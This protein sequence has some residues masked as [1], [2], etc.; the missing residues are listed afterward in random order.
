VTSRL[1][2]TA[3]ED[4]D[5]E[6]PQL[7]AVQRL[8][9]R[10]AA[11]LDG[12]DPLAGSVRSVVLSIEG[13]LDT[14]ALHGA[15][16]H[17]LA[18]HEG[19]SVQRTE[20]APSL[21]TL[22]LPSTPPPT[23]DVIHIL[24]AD[25]GRLAAAADEARR[26]LDP[27]RGLLVRFVAQPRPHGADVLVV[28]H[29]LACDEA[30]LLVLAED[31]AAA[32]GAIS[33]GGKPATEPAVGA[34]ECVDLQRELV[35]TPP[36]AEE[37]AA[38]RQVL[39]IEADPM[40]TADPI[41]AE[42]TLRVDG[43]TG[44]PEETA[45]AVLTALASLPEQ[46]IGTLVELDLGLR[47]RY[48]GPGAGRAVLPL[49]EPVMLRR[50]TEIDRDRA[51]AAVSGA[52]AT[53][54]RLE[55]YRHF[56][57]RTAREFGGGV[58]PRV[59]IELH[60]APA[61]ALP[62][63]WAVTAHRGRDLGRRPAGFDLVVAV[64]DAAPGTA[65]AEVRLLGDEALLDALAV[66]LREQLT[67]R[68]VD[69]ELVEVTDAE[70]A[71]IEAGSRYPVAAVLPTSPLQAGMYL[72][73]VMDEDRDVY[74]CQVTLHVG[75][76]LDAAR[77]GRAYDEV[78]ARHP[79]TRMGFTGEPAAGLVEFVVDDVRTEVAELDLRAEPDPDAALRAFR[80]RDRETR[81]VL[82]DPPLSRLTVV[83][84]PDGDVLV[85]TFHLLLWDGWSSGIVLYELFDRYRGE[86]PA[87]KEI[88]EWREFLRWVD[89]RDRT[90]GLARWGEYLAG[91]EP[92]L[93]APSARG[94]ELVVAETIN[95]PLPEALT[96][97]LSACARHLGVTLNALLTAALGITL[98]H[99]AG[100]P[101][102][103]FGSTV[104]GRPTELDGVAGTVGVFMNTVPVR[105]ELDPAETVAELVGRL[106]GDRADL[107]EFD[108]LG[109]GDIQQ[110]HGGREL[111]DSLYTLQ[112]FL[113]DGFEKFS[114]ANGIGDVQMVD[115]THFPL[116]WVVTPGRRMNVK[117]EFRPDLVERPAA[118]T[119]LARYV[120]VL[121]RL[122]ADPTARVGGLDVRTAAE[123]SA[124]T[125]SRSTAVDDVT[126]AELLGQQARTTPDRV[127][128]VFG[129]ERLTFAELDARVSRMARLLRSRGAGPEQ[130]VAL[131]LPRSVD[132]VVALFA[133]LRA[134]AA[135]LPLELE[136]PTERLTAL[137]ADAHAHLLVCADDRLVGAGVTALRLDDPAVRS[138]LDE[139]PGTDLTDE[140][141]GPFAPG[142]R[143]RGEFPAY[144]IYTSG[145]TGRPKGV[146]TPYRGL[147]NMLVNHRTEIFGPTVARAGG[148]VL[149]IA[150][151]VSFAFD[152][153]WEELL[154]L[155]DGHEV[156]VCDEQ[157][158][159]DAEA[160]VAYCDI[161]E[162]DSVNVTPT[163]AH[164]LFNAGL[165]DD[166]PGRHRPVL[167]LLGGEAV[168]ESVWSR[169][170]DTEGTWGYNLY[171]PTEY[172]I[173]TLGGGTDDSSTSTV[174]RP[175]TNTR[176]HILDTWL[177]PVPDGVAGELYIS[178]IGLARGYLDQ[179]GLTAGTFVADPATPGQRMYR[180]GDV[181]RR[182][183]DGNLD[184]L[185]RGDDQ[186]KI[187]GYRVELGEVENTLA[188]VDGVEQVAVITREHPVVPG[189]RQLA[190]FLVGAADPA[191]VRDAAARTLPE[192]MVP[193][194]W[195]TVAA[196]PLTVNG[197]LD[198]ESLP[199]PA[200]LPS[201]SSRAPRTPTEEILCGIVAEVL[202]VDGI[203]I[204]DDFF[205]LGG[206][207]ISVLT[208]ANRARKA[209][210]RIRPRNV[211]E[212]RTVAR[213]AELLD[214]PM[215]DSAPAPAAEKAALPSAGR[216]LAEVAAT[217]RTG[218]APA[219][220]G[221]VRM[222]AHEQ[223][224]GPSAT[225]L[226]P[227]VHRVTGPLHTV[228]LAAAVA[229][230]ADR[231]PVLRTTYH[232]R[233][234]AV[235]QRVDPALRPAFDLRDVSA[236][237]MDGEVAAVVR[238]PFALDSECPLRLSV[239]RVA[240]EDHVVALVI[241]HIAVDEW[242]VRALLADLSTAYAAR[243]KGRAPE[244][245]TLAVS[246]ADFAT[247]QH[248]HL[249]DRADDDS[250]AA[251]QL[252]HWE[253]A[254]AGIPEETTLPSRSGRP[255]QRTGA[256]AEVYTLLDAELTQRLKATADR[257]QVS[258]FMLAHSA[259]AVLLDAHGCGPDVVIGSPISERGDDALTDVL[260]FFL[261]T[262]ALRLDL[263]GNPT[264]AEVLERA[265]DT[266]LDAMAH[267]D[268]PFDWVV[269]RV[270][271]ERSASRH[272]LFQVELV[273]LRSDM[274]EGGLSLSGAVAERV[275][276]ATGTAKFDATFQFYERSG[277]DP[278]IRLAVEYATDLFSEAEMTDIVD[279]LHRLLE[280]VAD[281]PER[282]LADLRWP[283]GDVPHSEPPRTDPT[284]TLATL[285]AEVAGRTPE[286]TAL[287]DGSDRLSYAELQDRAARLAGALVERGVVPG[288]RVAIA[289]PRSA[290]MLVAVLGVLRA[291]ATYVPLDV[292]A[293]AE[294]LAMI[295]D[296]SGARC[297][298]TTSAARGLVAGAETIVLDDCDSAAAIPPVPVPAAQPAY[299]IYTSGST[300]RPKGVEVPHSAVLDLLAAADRHYDFNGADAWSLFHSVAFDVSVF[301]M[302][303]AFAHGARLVVAD[304]DTVR[305][306]E[307]F[308]A[309]LERERV[310]VLSQTPSAFDQL[311]E[312]EPAGAGTALRY[313][314]FAGEALETRRLRPWYARHPEDAPRLVNMYGITETCVHTTF[315]E[316][317]AVDAE[318][319][320]SPVGGPLPGLEVLLFDR[321]L[322][323]VLPGVVGE[324]YVRGGQLAQGY[325][326]RPGL[327]A[328]RFVADPA[329]T[330][331]RLYRSGDLAR[332]SPDGELE[333]TGRADD[334]VK[335]RGF[336]VEPGEVE[337][338]LLA[339]PGVTRAVVVARP[340]RAGTELVAYVV[341]RA[342]GAT[343]RAE[344]GSALPGY[345][346]PAAVVVLDAIPLTLNGKLD[347]R[348]LPEPDLGGAGRE[349][350][351]PAEQAVATAFRRVLGLERVGVDDSFFALG[352]HSL[353][354]L[355]LAHGIA[356]ELGT[357]VS[358]RD[359]FEH[360]TVAGLA[361]LAGAAVAA[362]PPLR[363]LPRTGAAR[364]LSAGQRQM[365]AL[366]RMAGP[367][368]VY[369]VP[370]VLRLTGPLDAAALAAAWG[371]LVTRHEVLRT[372]HR[373]T[374]AIVLDPDAAPAWFTSV[375]VPAGAIDDRIREAV[376][377][378]F[379][380]AAEPPIRV[381]LMRV[382]AETHVL[383]A[384][385]HH[386]AVDEWS[387][388][389]LLLDL[390]RAY[391]A[392]RAGEEG[393]P[394]PR[395]QYADFAAWQAECLADG[396]AT[397]ATRQLEYWRD[398][399]AGAP[400]ECTLP[401]DRA[402]PTSPT[403]AGGV[404]RVEVGPELTAALH[405]VAREHD[406]T[407]FMLLHAAL[408]LLLSRH[409][410]SADVVIGTPISTRLDPALD[411][412]VGY[413][414]NTLA[415]RVDVAP[416]QTLAEL[417]AAVRAADLD[418]YDR[419]DVPFADVVT[420]VGPERRAG[421][422]PLFQV[423]LVCLSGDANYA[424]PVLDGLEV[425]A[426]YVGTRTAKFDA[427]LNFH[428]SP[429]LLT[430]FIEYSA[431]L[432]DQETA[433]RFA[434]RFV[435]VLGAFA[436]T[437]VAPIGAIDVLAP[438]DR[439][440]ELDRVVEGTVAVP[441][442]TV[443][444]LLSEQAARTP[445]RV[446]LVFG[447]ER[448]TFAELD[449]RVS[450]MA[451]LLRSRGAGPEQVVAL[452]LPRSVDMV[453]ALFAVLR[454]GAAYLPLELEHPTERLTALIA[455]AHAHLLVCADDRLVGAGATA[456]RLADPAV[457][458]ELD[459]LPGTDLTDEELGPF[460][461]SNT[462]RSEYPA[463]VIY[464][465]GS[466]GRPKGVVTP[467]RG[468]T[469]MLVN[470]RTEIFGPTVAR[471]GGR[472]LRIAHTVSFAFDMSWEELL[473]LVDGHE[474]HVCDEQLRR[475]AEALVAY[476]DTHEID[477]VNVTPTYAHH[478]FNAGLLDD[479]PGRHR[480]VLVLLGGEAVPQ[481][482]W[483][484]LRDT[485]DTW[486]Y[487]L[488][489]PTEY[490]INTL[491][492]GTDDSSTSTVGQ[493]ITNTRA[494]VLDT[495]LRPVPD[496][497][498]GELYISG[499]GLARGYL[500]Q[501]GLTAAT[502]VADPTTPGER[503]YRT[504]DV[505]RRRPDGNLDFLGRDDDQVK[506]RGY[507]VEL[508][509]VEN[510]LAAVDGVEQVAVITREHPEVP[511]QRQL[512]AFLAGTATPQ[513]VRDAATR[514]LPAY[515][516]PTLWATVAT[517]PLTVNSKLDKDALPEPTPVLS[518]TARTPRTPTEE[519][520]CTIVAAA[521]GLDT[522]G[523]DDDFF[524]LGGDSI[525]AI[526][527]V[528]RIRDAGLPV[529]VQDV[530]EEPTFAGLAARVDAA[531]IDAAGPARVDRGDGRVELTPVM[532][533]LEALGGP[534]AGIQ[535]STVL[536]VP[537]GVTGD[538][539]RALCS[540][541]LAAHPMLRARLVTDAVGRWD[542]LWVD[543]LEEIDPAALLRQVPGSDV[544]DDDLVAVLRQL[545]IETRAELDGG[546]GGMARLV[547]LD[548]GD[549]RE[550]RLVMMV[551]HLAVDGVS[552]RLLLED[553]AAFGAGTR[554]DTPS[555]TSFAVWARALAEHTGSA[556]VR[557]RAPS[558]RR[559]C[560]GVDAL[561]VR[562][563]RTAA[564]THGGL[565]RHTERGTP[566]TGA[567]V[568]VD[569][570]AALGTGVNAVLLTALEVSLGELDPGPSRSLLV[571]VEGHGR[572]EHLAGDLDLSTTV[573]CFTSIAPVRLDQVSAA[574]RGLLAAAARARALDDQLREEPD[575]GLSY[576]LLRYP[577]TGEPGVPAAA[578]EVAFNYLGRLGRAGGGAWAPAPEGPQARVP[579]GPEVRAGHAL[580]LTVVAV[581]RPEGTVLEATLT[582]PEG[583]LADG[584]ARRVAR[585]WLATL[586]QWAD[587]HVTQKG[588]S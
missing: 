566:G 484:R 503:M 140:E 478:L 293:P 559:R 289:V 182:R 323:P 391:R 267:Q 5:R 318:A 261:N 153:S 546:P 83:R 56:D 313:V 277:P 272:P 533:S 306:P 90:A 403:G 342:D 432:Y 440:R 242:S 264:L 529:R 209:K 326:G 455:D 467:Y 360:P 51:A 348:A 530:L 419:P 474:V 521:L 8:A 54:T 535:Q 411:D 352:G 74:Y 78:L 121:E 17:V 372:V 230:L 196:L 410:E 271:P 452:G 104:S 192:Y 578:A 451:R 77:L 248:E 448:L 6:Q 180:T 541:L 288:D 144:V 498:A 380:L 327:T 139:L 476:C 465:S 110:Q 510:T 568:V 567:T 59:L 389:P 138:E 297:A 75:Y 79:A 462:L 324:L 439:E 251:A 300:G 459:A 107:M 343:I 311:L 53:G 294:R 131:G 19:L 574:P 100:R 528:G 63:G 44:R 405:R 434:Q 258:M 42:R 563:A 554:R 203:G 174:G 207:S 302:W 199:E 228:A 383:V 450:R 227:V 576:G 292:T 268:V 274:S 254:L 309:L 156:H 186:V 101:G 82:S 378:P 1:D 425:Q 539:M 402:R 328:G 286:A 497:V 103:T 211:F 102:A 443:A 231:H 441:D 245:P 276:A 526:T 181:V 370:S 142:N 585:R 522:V 549:A 7:P 133:V 429:D 233:D 449:A 406:V 27:D 426:D 198:K 232:D 512:A 237:D 109:L 299:V 517:L 368:A 33:G 204:D 573:G 333:F 436:D 557:E 329:G 540:S 130:V 269:E 446:A 165:L 161:H 320:V 168:P 70:L 265:R 92:T 178:G 393:L 513:A 303:G 151:T 97:A 37:L 316:L 222:W 371:D 304:Q 32:Y 358:V 347:R 280:V 189:Q 330:G 246:Y 275:I 473:W 191:A 553:V 435:A 337:A 188:A 390:E 344:L 26:W 366:H 385:L 25:G 160:L 575:G 112:N 477:S 262:L 28:A 214:G 184:F 127:A 171:G 379:D 154:W 98:A 346:V 13:E 295:L 244:F 586:E 471:A 159:R 76:R 24:A 463:Y 577:P 490:T 73:A 407:V 424:V 427:A 523:I 509:E 534:V 417:L 338:A 226:I 317:R 282:R 31:L 475:D 177:R 150:H 397:S 479:G 183:P 551:H 15:V 243:R 514:T 111:F 9:D 362:R 464:T 175:I 331:G 433:D 163:Y 93:L 349:P 290:A 45:A 122:I 482:V 420:A 361:A 428:D 124:P 96:E 136:H 35:R 85:W 579:F 259:L 413:F 431:D 418:A 47:P 525:T 356:A 4:A 415:L 508:G 64:Y 239:L 386:I 67:T 350:A 91:L 149:R 60:P 486:G 218:D 363:P 94:R 143:L 278:V 374:E 414:L 556:E 266:T 221:Q 569:L 298:V 504:G 587:E 561:P 202:G 41:A 50:P 263:G 394:A 548:R 129:A 170:R 14:A 353:L 487:N 505:V 511:G 65:E 301:E 444:D 281:A 470:H 34:G 401:G 488:Y 520:L 461:R 247:W 241:H 223:L 542:H 532:R 135:Y 148:R 145:S 197:K 538:D 354:A 105:V 319:G 584:D 468:L 408:A 416:E 581:D 422:S 193:T 500:D 89:T 583:V 36:T 106:H 550:G 314:V 128:L 114:R 284:G 10:A 453:V 29:D 52:L 332:W 582:W 216:S 558:W 315:R 351:T 224:A 409:T 68:R 240:P 194:L 291:G 176:G 2:I 3:A 12:A 334:Q 375:D 398:T 499:I 501:P 141:L 195:A 570:P 116:T 536:S 172:T 158:R 236:A 458:A 506:I 494:H 340:G 72:Q 364:P 507:R 212:S 210:L 215:E 545:G 58:R 179:P 466:T 21:W 62:A 257:H 273:Y 219:S 87:A 155:V 421:R 164:H 308:W 250:L 152:M 30:G 518:G 519:A 48:L 392:R 438:A 81:F 365:W 71:A 571:D 252:R 469:N 456:V 99:H 491:G 200:P 555:G 485:E 20:L 108:Y 206:D 543:R 283:G 552:W 61:A 399:L 205:T 255:D 367:S 220:P 167:V 489:G 185:G 396:S 126:V 547:W 86:P 565:R 132:M 11:D 18:R 502:F 118:E 169:L 447:A 310:T 157:L 580:V 162:I 113:Q 457:R 515:M 325:L 387:W 562:R 119:L 123:L 423:M 336:R 235:V 279:R 217:A 524:T 395:L 430:G 341:A 412:A 285:F 57:P 321:Y 483:S 460:A 381:T 382:D 16:A 531:R 115:H 134:G 481:S 208:L 253:R 270:N 454:A 166:G 22:E 55:L 213:L 384:V 125:D 260:G 442:S 187:R 23:E 339:V 404:A 480:P 388:R 527:V 88:L 472:V 296:D 493:A 69:R 572:V 40:T 560:D 312:A 307:A 437:A 369:N 516:V 39:P 225:Y 43:S 95:E 376:E 496:G 49:T 46:A 120:A 322:R 238:T 305:S 147:T 495:W 190:A 201:S 84:M 256:G 564:D 445:D 357:Q 66:P 146:V 287:V 137:I 373:D 377:H 544:R 234:G 588:L 359:V 249:G 80:D 355:R 492:G 400:A 229:D 537:A 335:I 345:M 173:N 117:L 38:W